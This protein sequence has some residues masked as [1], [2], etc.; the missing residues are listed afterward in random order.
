MCFSTPSVKA[1]PPIAP[2]PPPEP[3]ATELQEPEERRKKRQS[4]LE[5]LR[6]PL[7]PTS[8]SQA[9]RVGL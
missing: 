8:T 7:N 1:P 4:D 2:P 3:S 5:M 6:I 9:P